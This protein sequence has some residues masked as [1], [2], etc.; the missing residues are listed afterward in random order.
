MP[1][2]H[3]EEV[4][5]KLGLGASNEGLRK[6]IKNQKLPETDKRTALSFQDFNNIRTKANKDQRYKHGKYHA[7]DIVSCRLRVAEMKRMNE[8]VLETNI[9]NKL[10]DLKNAFLVLA[11]DFQIGMLRK[12]GG[13]YI[14]LDS[15]YSITKYGLKLTPL[16]VINEYGNGVTAAICVSEKT[17]ARTWED[18]FKA[19]KSKLGTAIHTNVFMTDGDRSYYNAWCTVMGKPTHKLLCT[20]HVWKCWDKQM[21]KKLSRSDPEN[22]DGVIFADKQEK[23]KIS[24]MLLEMKRAVYVEDFEVK[25]Q[26]VVSYLKDHWKEYYQ[27]FISKYDNNKEEWAHCYRSGLVLTTNNHVESFFNSL[28]KGIME[29]THN[30][31]LDCL[32]HYA[33][34]VSGHS[35]DKYRALVARG[36]RTGEQKNIFLS[37]KEAQ[38]MS[39]TDIAK[40]DDKTW[41]TK[42][43]G[44]P[45]YI[46]LEKYTCDELKCEKCTTCNS[47][48]HMFSCDCTN[49]RLKNIMCPHIHLV[50]MLEKLSDSKST[51]LEVNL[52]TSGLGDP[53]PPP[54]VEIPPPAPAVPVNE[55][56]EENQIIEIK[57]MSE[58]VNNFLTSNM[59]INVEETHELTSKFLAKLYQ[60]NELNRKVV[61]QKRETQKTFKSKK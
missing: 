40:I 25:Y 53:L 5:Y 13:D 56:N 20:W 54:I 57:S 14:L 43:E 35:Q 30:E 37:H 36:K 33:L 6:D 44:V 48:I 46:N 18:F 34:S 52:S 3:R 59:V 7:V 55:I 21:K 2:L 45:V 38:K 27:Y 39:A 9:D 28:K 32:I 15:T 31:R 4:Q 12:F 50:C 22:V 17:D 41:K 58:Q 61:P 49:Y 11:D 23:K 42:C 10:V 26:I 51:I 1:E 24:K 16:I 19:V 8:I 47:C 60:I 29:G